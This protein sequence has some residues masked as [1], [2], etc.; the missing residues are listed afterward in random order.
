MQFFYVSLIK[1]GE[2]LY[3][4][5]DFPAGTDAPETASAWALNRPYEKQIIRIMKKALLI[6][7]FFTACLAFCCGQTTADTL[8][9]KKERGD[10]RFY[11]GE[12]RLP[13]S[14]FIMTLKSNEQAYKQFKSAQANYTLALVLSYTGGFLIGYPIGTAIG[15]GEPE[16]ALAGI[17]LGLVAISFPINQGYIVKTKSAINTY[18]RSL[19]SSTKRDKSELKL[20]LNGS[21]IGLTL[22][23]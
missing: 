3:F 21:G 14:Q 16:W 23:F 19:Q 17:G 13:T 15:G 5:Q 18:N 4:Y 2:R 10:Y 12:N 1:N 7:T 20:T 6:L 9:L 8:T 11:Q 22:R